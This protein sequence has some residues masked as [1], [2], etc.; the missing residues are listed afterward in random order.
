MDLLVANEN[1]LVH[2]LMGKV[3]K[4]ARRIEVRVRG[5]GRA[6]KAAGDVPGKTSFRKESGTRR[7]SRH[8][9]GS[10]GA[11]VPGRGNS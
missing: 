6:P 4:L 1:H 7:T 8:G 10:E 5:P 3:T 9:M 11:R 2:R